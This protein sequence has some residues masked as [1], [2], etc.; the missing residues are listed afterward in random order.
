MMGQVFTAAHGVVG[1]DWVDAPWLE[2]D[3]AGSVVDVGRGTPPPDRA[4]VRDLGSVILLPGFVNAHSHAFQ[5]AIRGRTHRRG[6][7]DPSSFWSW[8][9]A[10]YETANRLTPDNVRAVSRRA[11]S[12][13]LRAG[14]TCVGEFHYLHHQPSGQPYDD[15]NELGRQ[16]LA[17]AADVGIRI[18]LLDVY[19]ARAGHGQPALPEQ[20]RFCDG[21]TDAYLRRVDALRSEGV[22]LGITPHSVRAVGADDLRR[23]AEYANTHGL[24]I[25]THLSEQP[26]ENEETM[27]E[28]GVTPARVFADADC[29]ARPRAFTAV[30]AVHIE[31]ADRA[32]LAEQ[33]VCACPTTEADLGDGIVGAVR[34]RAA[35]TRLALGSDSNAVIDLIQEARL[36]EMNER[37][38]R[39]ARL[40]LNDAEGRLWP[41]LLD[42]MTR[43]GASALGV[44]D[45][46]GVLAV[47]RPFDACT[48]SLDHPFLD[49]LPS[50]AALDAALASGTAA[51]IRHVFVGGQPRD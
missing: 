4:P 7:D 28:H 40:R 2:V 10:M 25:H 19:Y 9:E 50:E 16:V 42:S 1:G 18:V 38:A 48:V 41:V 34:L 22:P 15:A 35:G 21:S 43:G 39:Q 6:H 30:H 45:A 44:A 20:R 11:F 26:R 36:L 24:P 12:E 13:M 32:L 37:L 29:L 46:M 17:A 49:G 8:R 27:V 33:H 5:R 23:I 3:A 14:I 31:D 51:V 47:G